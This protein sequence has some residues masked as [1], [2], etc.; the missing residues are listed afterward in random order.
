[1]A[2]LHTEDSFLCLTADVIGSRAGADGA[3]VQDRVRDALARANRGFAAALVVPFSITVG[4]EFQGLL[5]DPARALEAELFLR[6]ALAP[7]SIRCGLG[8]GG[9]AGPIARR[10]AEMDG[11]C[12]HRSR[13]ALEE[14][15][16]RKA[17][18]TWL[19]SGDGRTDAAA[20]ACFLLLAALHGRWSPKQVEALGVFL[21]AG[22]QTAAAR[23]LGLSQPSLRKRL[24]SARAPEYL[25]A[26]ALLAAFLAERLDPAGPAP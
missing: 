17:P 3:P 26:R 9:V 14:A 16:G 22:S 11:P 25:E 4:D 13:A 15:R 21:E 20:N 7:L 8:V 6:L 24:Q 12:F 5:R 1:M 2:R 18:L 19:R 23:V 10:T